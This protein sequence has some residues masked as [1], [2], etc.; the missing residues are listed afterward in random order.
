MQTEVARPGVQVSEGTDTGISINLSRS[1]VMRF[2]LT[3]K[4]VQPAVQL[5]SVFLFS[6]ALYQSFAGAQNA[7]NMGRLL[8]FGLWWQPVMMISLVL[9]GRAW[10]YAC[11]IGAISNRLQRFSLNRRFP[12]F[13]NPKW[14]VAGLSLSILSLTALTFIFARLPLYKLGVVSTPWKI[15]VYFGA[16]L[17]ASIAVTLVFRQRAFCRYVCPASGVMSVTSKLSPVEL[18]QKRDTGVPDCMTAEF[19]SNYLS[20]DR[21]C[22]ACMHCTQGQPKASVFMRFRWPGAAAVKERISLVDE[23]LLALII[24]AVFPID[25]ALGSVVGGAAVI[26]GLP[27]FLPKVTPYFIDIAAAILLFALVNRIAAFWSRLDKEVSFTRFA[28]AYAP[29]G[30]VFAIT[31]QTVAGLMKSGGGLL[32]GLASGFGIPL[33]LQPA[34]AS[35][36]VVNLWTRLSHTW[37]L[38]LAVLWGA[39]IAWKIARDMTQTRTTALKAVLPHLGLMSVSMYF[40]IQRLAIMDMGK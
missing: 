31:G 29:L 16:I 32:N 10:C 1:R 39:I 2:L 18:R 34:W 23:A 14:R 19:K 24:W 5:L 40:V 35:P 15:G 30:I 9:F 26:K 21:R 3:N 11:P 20:T 12:I 36:A 4:Y 28:L 33:H 8:F 37:F 27:G 38:W 22:V 7:N 6:F 13:S 17:A 25:H